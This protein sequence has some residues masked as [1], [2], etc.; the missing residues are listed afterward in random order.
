M[1]LHEMGHS[2]G[3]GHNF[4]ASLDSE[5]YYK[6]LEELK[7]YFPKAEEPFEL[8]KS[9]S[10]IDYLPFGHPEM[11]V[12]GKYDLAVLRYL[13]LDQVETKSY[14]GYKKGDIQGSLKNL[15]TLKNL[16]SKKL[17]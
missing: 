2:F 9:S 4:K 1:I 14:K 15:E 5:N 10:V 3:L 16:K 6:S 12:L 8:A 17:R 13:Y 7:R 11:T